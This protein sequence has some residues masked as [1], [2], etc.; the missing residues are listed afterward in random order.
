MA[1]FISVRK[2]GYARLIAG[3]GYKGYP[4]SVKNPVDWR[5]YKARIAYDGS[6]FKGW[7]KGNGRTVQG[8]LEDS[9]ARVLSRL[10]PGLA[11]GN[12]DEFMVAGAGRT[13]A[14]VHA[15]GQVASIRLPL[16]WEEAILGR[17]KNQGR[18]PKAVPPGPRP[19]SPGSFSAE[20]RHSPVETDALAFF[21]SEVNRDLPQ[22]VSILALE[23]A[24]ER[25][26]A[27]YLAKAKNYRVTVLEGAVGDPFSSPYSWRIFEAL[28][29]G[30]MRLAARILEGEHDF[31]SF[32]ADKSRQSRV[33]TIHS[34]RV[35]RRSGNPGRQSLALSPDIPCSLVD[36]HFR[37]NSFLWNQVRIMAAAL[38]EVGTHV[39][40]PESLQELLDC[41]DRSRAPGPAP[42]ASL[43]L[44]SVEYD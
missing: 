29:I 5:A 20:T 27:R 37:G 28:D 9:F 8:I 13:D 17:G 4:R 44:V 15:L 2:G 33:K 41:R 11:V 24:D 6:H 35:E 39:R 19:G 34:V 10:A 25:F 26:H 1:A 31:T 30:A 42:A 22:D 23:P 43:T 18:M 21:L 12:G 36:I 16:G 40:P 3:T 38:V 7:Q 32:T 14:G